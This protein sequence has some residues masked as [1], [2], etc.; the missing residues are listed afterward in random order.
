MRSPEPHVAFQGALG[1]YSEEAVRRAFGERVAPVPCRENRDV[2]RAVADG[3]VDFGVLPVENSLAGSVQ[4]TYDAILG[5]PSVRA[6]GHLVVPIHHCVL[7]V[8]GSSLATLRVVE[9]HP[10]ALAQ[11]TAF[12]ERHRELEPRTTYD[13]AG[14]AREIALAGDPSRGAL[15]GA[16]AAR[17]YGLEV[18]A[19]DVEDRPDN[20]TRFLVLAREAP[21][22]PAGTTARTLLAFTT[23]NEPGALLRALEPLAARGLN[24]VKIESRPDT[25]PWTYRFVVEFEHAAGSRDAGG[26]VAEIG[27]VVAELREIGTYPAGEAGGRESASSQSESREIGRAHV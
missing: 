12:F 6:I 8:R 22:V 4:A 24:M 14:S 25:E 26:A 18:L 23:K 3:S 11:C 2:T 5:E 10:V 17:R 19:R 1:A 27:R 16:G 7:G 13:T 15:A 20:Q 21:A 9:S